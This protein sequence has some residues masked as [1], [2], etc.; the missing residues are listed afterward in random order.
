MS[1]L[2]SP[3]ITLWREVKFATMGSLYVNWA[4]KF[5]QK[6]QKEFIEFL[7]KD[8][9]IKDQSLVNGQEKPTFAAGILEKMFAQVMYD[10]TC[11]F[12]SNFHRIFDGKP[13]PLSRKREGHDF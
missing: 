6:V 4:E 12:G 8:N 11:V 10:F 9:T 1:D 13:F 3:C 7:D 5:E 2:A